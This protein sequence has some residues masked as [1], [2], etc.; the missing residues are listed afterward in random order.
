MYAK[1]DIN[2]ILGAQRKGEFPQ[3][4]MI[5]V[6][7][8]PITRNGNLANGGLTRVTPGRH[9]PRYWSF[10]RIRKKDRVSS[11]VVGGGPNDG[12]AASEN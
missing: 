10:T 12:R 9:T 8:I 1:S 5:E 6:Q 3:I 7:G 4:A 2:K 11:V